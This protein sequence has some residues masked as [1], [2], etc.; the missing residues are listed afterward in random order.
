MPVI[1]RPVST[2]FWE[3]DKVIDTFTPEDKYFMLYLL[4]NPHTTQI[5]IYPL[6]LKVAAFE[7][8]YSIDSVSH[9]LERFENVH[10]IIKRSDKTTEIAIKNFLCHSIVKGGKPVLD[11]LNK[12]IKTIKDTSLLWFVVNNL[13]GRTDLTD[14]IKSF[15]AEIKKTLPPIS[16]NDNDNDNDNDNESTVTV[17]RT[18][19]DRTAKTRRSRKNASA[20]IPST[21]E[22]QTRFNSTTLAES[23]HDWLLYKQERKEGYQATGLKSLLTQIENKVKKHS[24]SAVIGVITLSMSNNWKGILW[25]KIED[26]PNGA[27]DIPRTYQKSQL[28]VTRL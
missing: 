1:K 16:L 17:R 4:T 19:G 22:L 20:K 26:K 23:V 5:G 28:N 14:T 24:E 18:Y 3:D 15:V 27:N 21:E 25:E 10:K 8:G 2:S 7:T 9:L 11:C 6:N 12:E 13:S